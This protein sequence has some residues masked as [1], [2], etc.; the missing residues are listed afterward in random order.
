MDVTVKCLVNGEIEFIYICSLIG[1]TTVLS[2]LKTVG[3]QLDL[4]QTTACMWFNNKLE[5]AFSILAYLVSECDFLPAICGLFP[6]ICGYTCSRL[7]TYNAN[8]KRVMVN[9]DC[10]DLFNTMKIRVTKSTFIHSVTMTQNTTPGIKKCAFCRSLDIRY[11]L[12]MYLVKTLSTP[13]KLMY[14]FT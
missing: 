14:V 12:S 6:R 13:G 10:C 4:M 1:Y 5:V 8:L 11:P 7:E 2:G 9:E 3:S